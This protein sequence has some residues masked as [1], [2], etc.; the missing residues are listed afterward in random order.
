M[1]RNRRSKFSVFQHFAQIIFAFLCILISPQKPQKSR[2][3]IFLYFSRILHFQDSCSYKSSFRIQIDKQN[4][5]EGRYPPCKNLCSGHECPDPVP[6]ALQSFEDNH[7]VLP[8]AV[9]EELDGL[10]NADGETGA[11]A[12]QAIRFLE[13]LRRTGSLVEGVPLPSGGDLRL[14]TNCVDVRLPEGFPDSKNDNRILKVALGLSRESGEKVVLVTKDIVVR[15]K[16]QIAGIEAEDFTTEQAPESAKQYTGRCEVYAAENKFENFKK[17]GISPEDVY[18]TDED[19]NRLPLTLV[20]NQFVILKAEQ[21]IRKTQL[22]RF[23]GERIVPLAHK[24]KKPYGVTPRNVGQQFLQEALMTGP[25][26]APLVIVKGMAG[27]AK[28]FYTYTYIYCN[29][30]AGRTPL[31]PDPGLPSQC[32]V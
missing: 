30:G 14:E 7:V 18:Q 1:Y 8:L 24:K 27:T 26:E 13:Q 3:R 12:R 32:P 5:Q 6:A 9:L 28:T 17:K 22:G 11:N 2:N 29:D 25:E 16:A 20:P 21:S 19:G 23:N 4:I 31:P 10:K 15:L